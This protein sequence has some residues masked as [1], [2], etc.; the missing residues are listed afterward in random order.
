MLKFIYPNHTKEK[1]QEVKDLLKESIKNNNQ[2]LFASSLIV[3]AE[4]LVRT[5][6]SGALGYM[7]YMLERYRC[8]IN[9]WIAILN[10]LAAFVIVAK[11]FMRVPFF[12][13]V[14]PIYKKKVMEKSLSMLEELSDTYDK[15]DNMSLL[16][17]DTISEA[18]FF[19]E[20]G[21]YVFQTKNKDFRFRTTFL[22]MTKNGNDIT[23][24]FSPIDERVQA[25]QKHLTA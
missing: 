10:G 14:R 9:L 25:I 13:D 15:I 11:I 18:T 5:L 7:L 12:A 17:D 21:E 20:K 4:F 19:I 22:N 24:N 16:S 8:N 1:Y 6:L 23:F 3:V 2:S